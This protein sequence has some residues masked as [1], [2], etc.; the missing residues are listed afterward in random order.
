MMSGC[1]ILTN[2]K[3]TKREYG[4]YNLDELTVSNLTVVG[5]SSR[6]AKSNSTDIRSNWNGAVRKY[7]HSWK[8]CEKPD[9][10]NSRSKMMAQ[11]V[12]PFSSFFIC[13]A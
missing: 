1:G 6:Y 12:N 8:A 10:E 2:G 7:P 9:V 11:G 5:W 13:L 3:G 4:R